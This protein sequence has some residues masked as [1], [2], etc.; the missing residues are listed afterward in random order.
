MRRH[1]RAFNNTWKNHSE[2]HFHFGRLIEYWHFASNWLGAKAKDQFAKKNFKI[3]V[4]RQSAKCKCHRDIGVIE[5]FLLVEF[6]VKLAL[7]R[8]LNHG[9]ERRDQINTKYSEHVLC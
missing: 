7:D 2:W 6:L 5:A 3:D 9:I 4:T 1:N 8:T